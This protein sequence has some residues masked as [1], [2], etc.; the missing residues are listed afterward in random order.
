LAPVFR[1]VFH[2]KRIAIFRSN[3]TP[4]AA[5]VASPCRQPKACE[6]LAKKLAGMLAHTANFDVALFQRAAIFF[7]NFSLLCL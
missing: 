1:P 5:S 3:V 6:Q 7:Y 2:A 4:Q